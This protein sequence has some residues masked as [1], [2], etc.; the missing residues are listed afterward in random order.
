MSP[1]ASVTT[2]TTDRPGHVLNLRGAKLGV[3]SRRMNDTLQHSC[4]WGCTSNGGMSECG[5]VRREGQK[6]TSADRLTLNDD[7]AAVRRW[8]INEFKSLGCKITVDQMGNIFAV[9][10]GRSKG[11]PIAMGSHLDTQPTGGR[12]DGI[13]TLR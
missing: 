1:I 12:Y 2:T 6:P 4:Q 13:S 3:N 10:P 8:I 9:R 7:D 11:P 5:R